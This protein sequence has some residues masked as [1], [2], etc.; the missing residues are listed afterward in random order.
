MKSIQ[1]Y[2]DSSNY[3]SP[4]VEV[5]LIDVEKGFSS[6]DGGNES[7]EKEPGVWD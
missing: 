4:Q 1:Q 3:I 7:Y 2:Y 5:I 6:S